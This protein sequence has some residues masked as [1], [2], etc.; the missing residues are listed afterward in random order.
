MVMLVL[1]QPSACSAAILPCCSHELHFFLRHASSDTCV[2]S[3]YSTCSNRKSFASMTPAEKSDWVR[4]ALRMLFRLHPLSSLMRIVLMMSSV[5][6]SMWCRLTTVKLLS[7]AEVIF[8]QAL[9]SFFLFFLA[10][11][12][13]APSSFAIVIT[14]G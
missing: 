8:S 3:R 5:F 2:S 10:F 12:T 1:P 4:L 9:E 14:S 6:S 11:A 7:L 13:S